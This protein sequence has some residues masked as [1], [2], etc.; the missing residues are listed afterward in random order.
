M[1]LTPELGVFRQSRWPSEQLELATD[2]GDL[3]SLPS[4]VNGSGEAVRS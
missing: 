3:F 4:G 2:D 1:E